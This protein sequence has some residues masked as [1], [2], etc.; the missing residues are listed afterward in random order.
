MKTPPIVS[1]PEWEAARQQLLVK[2]KALTRARDALAAERR[3]M[4]WLAVEKEYEFD[5][6][7]GQ[8]E[9]A[10][11]VRG[12]PSADRLP[13]LL[14]TGRFRL[15]RPCLPRMLPGSRPGRPRH[16]SER[17]RH[18]SRL[19]LARAAAGHRAREGAD[20]LGDALVHHDRRLRHRLR[21]GRMA[22]HERLHPRWRQRV[23]HLLHQQPR[24]RSNGEHLE[25]PRPDRA[26]APGGL[27]GLARG[28]PPDPTVRSGGTGTTHTATP[29]GPS[30]G[31]P[32][33][34]GPRL[35]RRD[36]RQDS[37]DGNNADGHA[38]ARRRSLGPRRPAD[39]RDGHGR[40]D[41]ARFLRVLS[42]RCGCR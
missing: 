19:R 32:R 15:A 40:R 31:R 24:R 28:L 4:P 30:N 7:Q 36:Q 17:P 6:P 21:R 35:R 16:P 8:G 29:S 14:R 25:L 2:E 27:G 20:G 12:P 13:R 34:R 1:A 39:E 26:R 33:A 11:P 41:P 42:L 9:P 22:W 3:Q 38:R 37:R 23:P 10:R 18:H 5:G